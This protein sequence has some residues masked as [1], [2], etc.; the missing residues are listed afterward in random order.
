MGVI[1][2]SSKKFMPVLSGKVI[3]NKEDQEVVLVN[4]NRLY[5]KLALAMRSIIDDKEREKVVEVQKKALA[6]MKTEREMCV[7]MTVEEVKISFGSNI[8]KLPYNTFR[9][10]IDMEDGNDPHDFVKMKMLSKINYV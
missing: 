7:P 1:Q 9:V 3:E 5:E 4:T 10:E 6:K 8:D 2:M